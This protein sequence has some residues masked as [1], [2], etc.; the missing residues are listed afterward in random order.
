ME[1]NKQASDLVLVTDENYNEKDYLTSN[2][3]VAKAVR[4]GQIFSGRRHFN[5]HGRKEGR[6]MYVTLKDMESSPESK[7]QHTRTGVFYSLKKKIFQFLY[8][9]RY[10][11]SFTEPETLKVQVLNLAT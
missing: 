1:T 3:D 5:L 10:P 8:R 6:M 4:E 11:E 7:V 2:P 9:M